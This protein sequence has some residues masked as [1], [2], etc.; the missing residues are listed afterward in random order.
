M[1]PSAT[2]PYYDLEGAAAYLG[3]KSWRTV[4]RLVKKKKLQCGKSSRFPRFTEEQLRAYVE[5]KKR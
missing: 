5:G 2:S 1:T 3:F 4:S